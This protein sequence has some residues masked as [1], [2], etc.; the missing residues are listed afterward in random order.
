[1]KVNEKIGYIDVGDGCWQRI[2]LVTE[3]A[4]FFIKIDYASGI[5]I[6]KLSPTLSHQDNI[7]TNITVA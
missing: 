5:K 1:L 4:V 6:Q 3:L 2:M 7:V